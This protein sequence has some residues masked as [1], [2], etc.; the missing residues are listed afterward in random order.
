[1]GPE[2]AGNK[3][4]LG[5]QLSSQPLGAFYTRRRKG[6]AKGYA[7]KYSGKDRWQHKGEGSP[8]ILK[9]MQ[10]DMWIKGSWG[11]GRA[12]ELSLPDSADSLLIQINEERSVCISEI[13]KP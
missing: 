11:C 9:Q 12:S 2:A 6:L 3:S 4:Q 5:A 7:I 10:T 8:F 1:M 13:P